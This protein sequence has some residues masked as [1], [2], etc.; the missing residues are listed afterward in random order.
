[1]NIKKSLAI[2]LAMQGI[3]QKQLAELSGV[4][5][6]TISRMANSNESTTT[7]IR[8]VCG[9]LNMKVSEFIALGE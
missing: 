4:T 2:S 5:E 3:N 1:M 8:A 9:A 6:M 7:T